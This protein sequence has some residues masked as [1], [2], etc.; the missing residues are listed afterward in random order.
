DL[1]GK[2]LFFAEDVFGDQFCLHEGRVCSFDAET[3]ELKVLGHSLEDWAKRILDDYELLTGYP[4]IHKWQELHGP[5]PIGTRLMPKI[6]FVLGGGYSLD[7]LYV[8]ASVSAMKSRGNLARQIK[9][10]PD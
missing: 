8:L 3:G 9:D 7:N 10:L 5:V 1:I 2:F 6:P 4:L